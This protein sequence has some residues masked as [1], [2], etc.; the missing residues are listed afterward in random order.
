MKTIEYKGHVATVEFDEET[1]VFHGEVANLRDIV[2]F[3]GR[4]ERELREAF[5]DS[6]DDYLAFCA[7]RG[8]PVA[9]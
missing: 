7:E 2:T 9:T 4:T 6:L 3:E 8:Q 5:R 1:G